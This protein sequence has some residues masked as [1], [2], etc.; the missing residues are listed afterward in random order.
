M[1]GLFVDDGAVAPATIVIVAASMI[2]VTLLPESHLVTGSVLALGC[3]SLLVASTM[4]AA[5]E[6]QKAR[7]RGQQV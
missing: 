1:M 4:R 6:S 7:R 2:L 5:K 3:P